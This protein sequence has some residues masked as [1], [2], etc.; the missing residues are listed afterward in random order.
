MNIIPKTPFLRLWIV[1]LLFNLGFVLFSE[2]SNAASY[3]IGD[4]YG[5]G[6]I[7]YVDDTGQHGLIA[8]KEDIKISYTDVWNKSSWSGV[9]RWSTGQEESS[10]STDF[11]LQLMTGT[12]PAIGQGRANTRKILAKYP[13]ST[14]PKSAAAV[15]SA[16]RGGGF[17]DWFL[18]S[19]D[20]LNQLYINRAVIGD[21]PDDYFWSSTENTADTAWYQYFSNGYQSG[22]TKSYY[23]RVRAVRAF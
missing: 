15:A 16:Y 9:Y 14:Y 19:K 23:S 2:V 7:F 22:G 20:E 5:G 11:A 12:S 18:P 1:F 3:K 21:F 13:P 8:A 10:N 17:S 6:V 4:K